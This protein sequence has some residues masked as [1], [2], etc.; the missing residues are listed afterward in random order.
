MFKLPL[1]S[2]NAQKIA[3]SSFYVCMRRKE[4]KIGVKISRNS[5]SVAEQQAVTITSYKINLLRINVT[6][7]SAQSRAHKK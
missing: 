6:T 2:I 1:K 5:H 3:V 7:S 4:A